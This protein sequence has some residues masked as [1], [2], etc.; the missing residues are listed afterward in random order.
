MTAE[1]NIADRAIGN[2]EKNLDLIAAQ[3]IG[4]FGARG[5]GWQLALVAWRAIVVEN[6]LAVEIFE[7][8]HRGV[9][10]ILEWFAISRLKNTA[11][12]VECFDESINVGFG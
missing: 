2:V 12:V 7:V 4:P 5:R 3:W 9:S 6:D 1:A 8:A 10:F 11:H